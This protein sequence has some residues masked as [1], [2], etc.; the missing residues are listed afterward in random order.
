MAVFLEA[1]E[2]SGGAF[3]SDFVEREVDGVDALVLGDE[4]RERV[5]VDA[6]YAVVAQVESAE[7]A[8]V[9]GLLTKDYHLVQRGQTLR[10]FA[11]VV[12]LRADRVDARV[13]AQGLADRREAARGDLVPA[14]QERF[15]VR[16][17]PQEVRQHARALVADVAVVQVHV[18]RRELFVEQVDE[19][20]ASAAAA[21]AAAV[22]PIGC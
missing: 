2:Q 16:V 4:P 11:D 3:V 21:E 22:H 8:R 9:P 1:F 20:A 5:H 15:Y 17:A 12:P 14:Q 19:S 13:V 10:V 7:R 6:V 18:A